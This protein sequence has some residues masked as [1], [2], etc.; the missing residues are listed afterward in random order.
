MGAVT[1]LLYCGLYNQNNTIKSIVL[2]SPFSSL[3][4]LAKDHIKDKINLLVDS[5]FSMI[6]TTVQNKA[7][8]NMEDVS[9]IRYLKNI[10]NVPAFFITASNDKVVNNDHVKRLYKKYHGEKC[11]FV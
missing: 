10:K 5:A 7:G 4:K 1:V 6:N 8:F 11:L 9:P 2:D 3:K